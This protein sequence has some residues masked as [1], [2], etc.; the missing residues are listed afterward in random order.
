MI[1]MIKRILISLVMQS[2][3]VAPV[4]ALGEA[5]LISMSA[6]G[7]TALFNLGVHDGVVEGDYAVVVKEIRDLS[8]RDL[9][10]VPVA[11]ARNVKLSTQNSIWI[12]YKFYDAELLVKGQAYLILTESEMLK[13]RRDPRFGRISVIT[14]RDKAAWQANQTL[15]SDKDRIAKLK[16]QYPEVAVL[17]EKDERSDGDGELIDV[18]A[19]TKFKD[20]KYRTALYKS[21]HTKDFRREFRVSTFEKIV[22]AYLDKVNDPDFNY[23]RFYEEQKKIVFAN[24]FRD[25]SNFS[26]E[27]RKYVSNQSEK[28]RNDAKLY[29][30]LLEKGDSWSEDFSDE[31]LKH[32]LGEVSIL[33]EKDRRVSVMATPVRHSVFFNYG[34]SFNDA[35]TEKDSMYR[36]DGRYSLELSYET[37][38]I[39]HNETLKHFS[40]DASVRMNKTAFSF[41]ATNA[42]VDETSLSAGMNWYPYHVSYAQD[43]TV[44]FL[45]AYI[46]SGRASVEAPAIFES[47]N[48]TV[49][50]MPGLRAGMKYNFRNN[51]GLRLA[52]SMETLKL[53]KYERSTLGSALPDQASL[54]EGKMNFAMTYSF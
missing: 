21:P 4:W 1:Q 29:R 44:L 12:L 7:Q 48:Y 47:S 36:R 2:I 37:I 27:Y 51:V 17:H 16:D 33:Q 3:I 54:A 53:E 35:Q 52:L 42:R 6:S 46:R 45:G 26:T 8:T 14:E 43:A 30:S 38:P 5:R 40:L 28:T 22:T 39:L 50:A 31:E 13:G 15:A 19:W 32:L 11:K 10:I 9:R 25:R 49:L 23:D 34:M 18:E 41:D 20:S 24:E